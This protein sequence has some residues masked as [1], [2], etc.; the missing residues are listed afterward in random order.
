VSLLGLPLETKLQR[1]LSDSR[2]DGSHIGLDA[3]GTP[4]V[5][6]S[7]ADPLVVNAANAPVFGASDVDLG[8]GEVGGHLISFAAQG[9]IMG[10]MAIKILKGQTPQHIPVVR[11]S[12]L[13]MFD[14]QALK[15]WGMKESALPPGS[16]VLNRQPA[17]W[18]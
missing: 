11:G 1:Q 2:A 5:G 4:F 9:R 10:E 14:G 7:Q 13:Y 12:N 8:H 6:A 16:I 18:Q 3:A 17:F 15:R